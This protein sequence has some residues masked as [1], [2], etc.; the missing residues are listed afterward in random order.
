V[1]PG[2]LENLNEAD[3]LNYGRKKMKRKMKRKEKK[4]GEKE[5]R[6]PYRNK[7]STLIFHIPLLR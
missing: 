2:R 6:E 5:R 7:H 3:E 4:K 1:N